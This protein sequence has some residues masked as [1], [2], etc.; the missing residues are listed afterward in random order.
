MDKNQIITFF[1][2]GF[3]VVIGSM[4]MRKLLGGRNNN[5]NSNSNRPQQYPQGV[6]ENYNLIKSHPTQQ[7]GNPSQNQQPSKI[8]YIKN[9]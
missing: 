1:V 8:L 2:L 4:A 6:S 5:M 9:V 7:Y 3:G